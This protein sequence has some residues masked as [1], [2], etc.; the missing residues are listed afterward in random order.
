[1][2]KIIKI[3][4]KSHN[5]KIIIEKNSILKE[6]L[7]EEK[8]QKNF[9]IVDKKLLS[10]ISKLKKNKNFNLITMQG[11]EKIK[12]LKYFEDITN[13]LL[14]LKIDRESCIIAIGGGTIGDLSGFI[15]STVLRGVK[16]ILVPT[17]LLSQ[18]DSSIGGKNGVNTSCGK[19][20]V[21]TFYQP[22][23]VIIDH[24]ILNFLP[25][26][27]I[28]SGYAEILKHAMIKNKNFY[29]WLTKNFKKIIKL[30]SRFISIA[31]IESIKIKAHF[32]KIDE[33]E[34][35]INDNSRAM[36]NFGHTFGHALESMNNYK[37]NLSHGE[38]ISIGMC[39]AMK[40]SCK[41]NLISNNE[42]N[43]FILHLKDV[44]LP[45]SDKRIEKNTIYNVMM[46]DKKNTENLI[47][48]I[49]LK[50]IGK[51][52]YKRG[53]TKEKIKSYLIK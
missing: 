46:S 32:V 1:M 14:K 3:N 34:I 37:Q 39:L 7:K 19:N 27:Q 31:I 21:G 43:D 5:Y 24:S 30:E 12:S 9:I 38:A 42:Y 15:A 50:R 25:K 49:L 4:T 47:N 23:K 53:L 26:K 2:K 48:L 51:A 17:T 52:F 6:I 10:L 44:G 29:F 36:L 33:N 18:V 28:I 16:F 22:N 41:M 8:K 20:L 40:I 13:K 11:G 35:L 45:I